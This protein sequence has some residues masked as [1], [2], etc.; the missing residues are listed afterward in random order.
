MGWP[1]KH[2]EKEHSSLNELGTK[3]PVGWSIVCMGG[4]GV[5]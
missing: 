4:V 3:R 5:G 2:L 1:L